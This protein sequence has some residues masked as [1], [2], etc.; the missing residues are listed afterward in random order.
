MSPTLRSLAGRV[1]RAVFPPPTPPPAPPGPKYP[2]THDVYLQ[3]VDELHGIGG[4]DRD[5]SAALFWELEQRGVRFDRYEALLHLMDTHP[6]PHWVNYKLCELEYDSGRD[7]LK[8]YPPYLWMDI[9]SVCSVECRFCKYTHEQLPVVNLTLDQI[10]RIEWLKYVKWL[11]LTAGTAEAITN[12]QFLPIFDYLRTTFP[13]MHIQFLTN[14]RTL[15][16][17]V[18]NAIVGR[19]DKIHISM[20]ASSREDYER[21]IA[22]GNWNQ[23]SSNM[24]AM[25]RIFAGASRPF[26][27]ASF[28]MLRSNVDSTIRNLEFAAEHGASEVYFHH[29]YGHYINDIHGVNQEVLDDK[30]K[31]EDSLYFDKDL[32]DRV[33]S[34]LDTRAKELGI[35]V[36]APPLFSDPDA[37][38]LFGVRSRQPVPDSCRYPWTNM[39]LLWGFKSHREEVTIC[40]GLA[41][42]IGVYFDRESLAT[43]EGFF[44]VRNS[45]T[46][47]AYRRTVNGSHVN[48]ICSLCRK[49]DRF[50][51]DAV[52]P[53][54]RT[55]F[56]FAG[57]PVPPH[58]RKPEEP[59]LIQI[60]VGR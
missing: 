43:R 2:V 3:L 37:R 35:T 34:R 12:P 13:D 60:A 38:I 21:I 17:R 10:K 4:E 36:W 25:K 49:V 7:E 41:S 45:P 59:Q 26:V 5:I 52:Y 50:A 9:S 27:A 51:P 8:S 33:F 55:F 23:F 39:Y 14:G 11:N 47:R 22:S 18:L 31:F 53:D 46:L 1:K 48:P 20:N 42:D 28:V 58:F 40:C 56:E 54:Q 29:F 6:A 57:L 24:A 16:E 30:F 44:E 32:S 15:N 19:L